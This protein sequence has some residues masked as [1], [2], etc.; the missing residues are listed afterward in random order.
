M[1]SVRSFRHFAIRVGHDLFVSV[2]LLG[3]VCLVRPIL[4]LL[5]ETQI[6]IVLEPSLASFG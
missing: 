1:L 5:A 6:V 2:N 3:V 4:A